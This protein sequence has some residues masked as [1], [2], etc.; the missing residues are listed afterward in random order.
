MA[1][2]ARSN[3]RIRPAPGSIW[4]ASAPWRAER[5]NAWWKLCHASPNE[6]IAE[7]REVRARVLLRRGLAPEHV[8]DRVDAPRD[9]V[10]QHHAGETG[11]QE[12]GERA[13]RARR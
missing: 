11:P 1:Q 2:P 6:M 13:A 4:C 3:R 7:R 5:G 12:R 9:V 8:A 10:Q